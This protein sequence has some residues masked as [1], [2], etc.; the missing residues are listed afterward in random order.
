MAIQSDSTGRADD[1]INESERNATPAEDAGRVPKLEGDAK[2]HP[3]F[4]RIGKRMNC[5][6]TLAGATT[7]VP[8]YQNKTDNELY[9]CAAND[10][11]K[12]KFIGFVT[13]DGTDGNRA[14]FQ[15]SGVVSGFSN[16]AEGEKYYVQ[17]AAGTIGTT[18]GTHEVLVGIAISETE[19]LI[20]KGTLRA[21][22]TAN[23]GTASQ[24][25]DITTGFRP[26]VIRLFATNGAGNGDVIS[27][28]HG[29]WTN[30]NLVGSSAA[31]NISAITGGTFVRVYES[32]NL[33]DNYMTLTIANV[34]DTGFRIVVTETGAYVDGG[35]LIWEAEGDL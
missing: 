2:L 17:D 1:F 16:L 4:V 34:T 31:T 20:Q 23:F 32:S 12:L 30:G 5:G 33:G 3:F 27:V 7:P 11:A 6:E 25:I 18:P 14:D 15:G 28:A 19:L 26:K 35:N 29:I 13:S 8:V 21:N 24:N 9:T 10:T 22:G